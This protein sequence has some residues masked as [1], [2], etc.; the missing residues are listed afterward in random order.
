MGNA[1][2]VGSLDIDLDEQ[3]DRGRSA[4]RPR[5]I[6]AAGW[7]DVALRVKAEAKADNLSLLAGGV[8]FFAM[9]S[10]VPALVAVVS[11]YGLVADPADIERQVRDLT[12]ALPAEA[13]DLITQQLRDVVRSSETGLGLGAIAGALVA[14]WGASSAVKHLI[15]AINTTYDEDETRGFVRLRGLSILLALGAAVFVVVAVGLIAVLPAALSDTGL[16]DAARS[17]LNVV[18]WPLLFVAM[19]VALAVVYRFG[20]DRDN[21]RWRWVSWGAV[22]AAVAWVAASI[23]FAVYTANFGRYNETYGS[24][25]AVVVLLLWLYL[26]ALL[27]LLGSEIN[28][29]IE[30]QTARDTTV[31]AERPLGARGARMA[32]EVGARPV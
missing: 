1:S 26:S 15:S 17:V 6:P 8:A 29:E 14:L 21:P 12:R 24:L 16:G 18:R 27:V 20:P 11:I 30:H 19:I 23:G 7:R 28:A 32:D 5:E 31:G 9:L 3:G 13:R 10:L 4:E 2:I 25:G 22:V